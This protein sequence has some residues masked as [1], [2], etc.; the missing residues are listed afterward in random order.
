MPPPRSKSAPRLYAE[1][2]E[3]SRAPLML[4]KFALWAAKGVAKAA[5]FLVG[6]AVAAE[7]GCR[8]T[9]KALGREIFVPPMRPSRYA[10]IAKVK[11]WE[12]VRSQAIKPQADYVAAIGDNRRLLVFP[13][14]NRQLLTGSDFVVRKRFFKNTFPL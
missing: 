9:E 8:W 6:V 10:D 11:S 2:T 5:I 1:G 12:D 14:Q 7:I 3:E 13:N 4:L